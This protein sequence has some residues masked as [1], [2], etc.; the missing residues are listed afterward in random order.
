MKRDTIKTPMRRLRFAAACVAPAAIAFAWP[1]VG[2]ETT[3]DNDTSTLEVVEANSLDELLK[4][5]EE[6]RVLESREH[7]Q[8]EREFRNRKDQQAKMLADARAERRRQESRSSRLDAKFNENQLKIAQEQQQY[9]DRLGNLSELFG[10]VQQV[11]GD[12]RAKF[13]ASLISGQFPDR[14]DWLDELAAKMGKATQL[15]TIEDMEHLW[16]NLQQEMTE[17]ARVTRFTGKVNMKSGESVETEMVRVGSFA[18]IDENGYVNYDINLG[19][20]VELG[21]QPEAQFAATADD[22]F[23]SEGELVPFAV[24]PTRGSLLSLF[25]EKKTLAEMVG[26]PFGGFAKNQCYMPFCNGQGGYPGSIIIIVGIIGVVMAIERLVVL[27]MVGAKVKNQRATPRRTQRR[28]SAWARDQGSP[29]QSRSGYRNAFAQARRSHLGGDAGANAQHQHHSSDLRGRAAY[30]T[31]WHRHRDD[32]DFPIHH[33]VRRWRSEDDGERHFHRLDDHRTRPLRG[34][35]NDLVA[36]R[37][38]AAKPLHRACARRAGRGRGGHARGR[39]RQAARLK[40]LSGTRRMRP[41]GPA[42]LD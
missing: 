14:G 41:Q 12:T 21:R 22:L 5:V 40:R 36:R 39:V 29:R 35:P 8:R 11:A 20:L 1:A 34:H 13:Q 19:T 10:V 26:T 28:Q 7:V 3:A 2:Q 25:V 15:A 17:S 24:D 18:I 37:R 32:R 27:T 42:T 33:A 38:A 30:G 23:E 6:R 16:F 4:N 31:A 9:A